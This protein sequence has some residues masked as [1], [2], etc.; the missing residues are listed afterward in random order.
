MANMKVNLKIWRQAGP[1]AQSVS[2]SSFAHYTYIA[3]EVIKIIAL[4]LFGVSLLRNK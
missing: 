4:T 3:V 1:K 2:S